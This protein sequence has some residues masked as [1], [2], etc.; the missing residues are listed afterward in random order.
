MSELCRDCPFRGPVAALQTENASLRQQLEEAR[1]LI[2]VAVKEL[3]AQ[4]ANYCDALG[5][6]QSAN[7]IAILLDDFLAKAAEAQA[8]EKV[9]GG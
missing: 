3:D 4:Q 6:E 5:I 7:G 9:N 1:R 8:Q 2:R